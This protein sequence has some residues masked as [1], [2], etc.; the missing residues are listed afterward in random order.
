MIQQKFSSLQL[1][2]EFLPEPGNA[3]TLISDIQ[4]LEREKYISVVY[5]PLIL[6][7]SVTAARTDHGSFLTIKSS[8][9]LSI[10]IVSPSCSAILS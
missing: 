3:G 8:K 9:E 7:F 6:D 10:L 1:G 2:K 5:N 4:L